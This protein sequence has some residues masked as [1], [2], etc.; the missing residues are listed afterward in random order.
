MVRAL[1][2]IEK[3]QEVPTGHNVGQRVARLVK[4]VENRIPTIKFFPFDAKKYGTNSNICNLNISLLMA[5][6]RMWDIHG[7]PI[8]ALNWVVDEDGEL[9]D[10][11]SEDDEIKSVLNDFVNSGFDPKCSRFFDLRHQSDQEYKDRLAQRS[12]YDDP[13]PSVTFN[14]TASYLDNFGFSIAPDVKSRK[15][16]LPYR[17][18]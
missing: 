15:S 2:V 8:V 18:D 13:P 10:D 14:S 17:D 9:I 3:T 11:D 4:A 6:D 1:L 16:R 7:C 5:F 12:H